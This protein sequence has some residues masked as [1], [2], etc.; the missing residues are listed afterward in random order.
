MRSRKR[1]KYGNCSIMAEIW[2]I[3]S[4]IAYRMG[5][6]EPGEPIVPLP[7]RA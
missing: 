3:G 1:P 5:T 4:I 2:S 7:D 6:L